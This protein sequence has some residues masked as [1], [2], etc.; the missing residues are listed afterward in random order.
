MT[1]TSADQVMQ[2]LL[3]IFS[4]LFTMRNILMSKD[5]SNT[6]FSIETAGFIEQYEGVWRIRFSGKIPKVGVLWIP[7]MRER[8]SQ[9]IFSSMSAARWLLSMQSRV[10]VHSVHVF[11][12]SCFRPSGTN[13]FGLLMFINSEHVSRCWGVSGIV[14]LG[15]VIQ[16]FSY[17]GMLC[18]L[19]VNSDMYLCIY[20]SVYVCMLPLR[21]QLLFESFPSRLLWQVYTHNIV[22]KARIE[23]IVTWALRLNTREIWLWL[24]PPQW[25]LLE[26]DLPLG[27]IRRHGFVQDFPPEGCF[28]SWQHSPEL[29]RVSILFNFCDDNW[30]YAK[31]IAKETSASL[32]VMISF[33]LC[34]TEGA[35]ET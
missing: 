3:H 10:C 29:C 17:I 33:Q 26:P 20:V 6:E 7:G 21:S 12:S 9:A 35:P 16:G 25:W 28:F 8:K 34:A 32:V 5:V 18:L 27:K 24:Q 14:V 1:M 31:I 22:S 30:R 19:N 4:S 2:L 15:K 13:V 11:V 23:S